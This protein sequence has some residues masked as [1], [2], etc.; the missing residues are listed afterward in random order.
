LARYSF[1]LRDIVIKWMINAVALLVV[2]KTVKGLNITTQG[3]EALITLLAAAAVIGLVNAFIKPIILLLTLP[4]SVM[5]FGIF[6]LLI[7]GMLF[8]L[9]SVFVRG[10]EVTSV[11]GAVIGALVFSLVSMLASLLVRT[12][13]G[14]PRPPGSR[15]G[16]TVKYRVIE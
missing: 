12:G 3:V 2:V 9:T 13:P 8:A 4:I 10:F 16:T 15:G 6:T 11:W 14:G 1:G 5:T 7:N